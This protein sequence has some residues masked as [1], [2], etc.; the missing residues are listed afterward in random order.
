MLDFQMSWKFKHTTLVLNTGRI[1][2]TVALGRDL[3]QITEVL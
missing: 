3:R 2:T 1:V